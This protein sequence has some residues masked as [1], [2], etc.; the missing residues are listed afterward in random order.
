MGRR[1]KPKGLRQEAEGPL[2]RTSSEESSDKVRDLEKRLADSLDREAEA[3]EQ[4]NATAEILRLIAASP[5]DAQPVFDAIA[6]NALR[7]CNAHGAVVMRYDGTLM[8]LAA[9]DNV[10]L[11]AVDRLKRQFPVAPDRHNPSGRAILDAA[12]VHVPDLQAAAEFSA[13]VARQFGAGSHVSIPLLHRGRAI[14]VFGISRPTLGPFSDR[15]I[16]L[17]Q[18]FADQ[19][20]IAIENVRRFSPVAV[21]RSNASFVSLDQQLADG[22][23]ARHR[24]DREERGGAVWRNRRGRSPLRGGDAPCRGPP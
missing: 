4:H 6:T 1:A 5:D 21:C 7:L 14:G 23:S 8:H 22:R 15:Q 19:A 24:R 10:A 3:A 17:L 13:S 2:T 20:V 9:H 12:V 16:A 18:T 11:E